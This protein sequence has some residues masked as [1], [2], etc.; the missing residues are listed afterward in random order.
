M[1][2]FPVLVLVSAALALVLVLGLAAGTSVAELLET[3][4]AVPKESALL[5]AQRRNLSSGP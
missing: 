1:P 5:G 2:A 3:A 4:G